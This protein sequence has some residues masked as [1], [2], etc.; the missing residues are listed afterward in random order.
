MNDF[1]YD[2]MTFPEDK[3]EIM[4]WEKTQNTNAGWENINKYILEGGLIRNL[5]ELIETNYEDFP[6]GEDERK[7][8]FSVKNNSGDVIGFVICQ[9]FAMQ[10]KTPELFLQY[11]VMRP[12][13]QRRGYGK[14]VLNVLPDEVEK[15]TQIRPISIFSYVEKTNLASQKLFG[16]FG[17]TFQ[18]MQNS[19]YFRASGAFEMGRER[20]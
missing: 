3:N 7:L 9:E 1:Y 13:M 8:A 18:E 10:T 16:D 19:D 2:L 15:Q 14:R 6:I 5:G 12:D 11:I 17:C 20:I 4:G